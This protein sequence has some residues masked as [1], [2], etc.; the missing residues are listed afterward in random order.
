MQ[1]F[2][3]EI[4]NVHTLDLFYE[5]LAET[6]DETGVCL[7]CYKTSIVHKSGLKQFR[8]AVTVPGLRLLS[9]D[10]THYFIPEVKFTATAHNRNEAENAA[11]GDACEF[12][13]T[14]IQRTD[15]IASEWSIDNSEPLD[16]SLVQSRRMVEPQTEVDQARPTSE[17]GYHLMVLTPLPS[18]PRRVE[19]PSRVS[20]SETSRSSEG[21]EN[22][23]ESSGRFPATFTEEIYLLRRQIDILSSV[24]DNNN[25]ALNTTSSSVNLI[26]PPT[27][28][29]NSSRLPI[30]PSTEAAVA[31][32]QSE[33]EPA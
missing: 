14:F 7:P 8:S 17:G 11:A 23:P 27:M 10:A 31:E 33:I 24:V 13:K 3:S 6:A 19:N 16:Q 18:L 12:L 4:S 28:S 32:F 30:V 2:T 22:L 5:E 20:E 21:P 26:S 15:L 1:A 9:S 29:T 25:T